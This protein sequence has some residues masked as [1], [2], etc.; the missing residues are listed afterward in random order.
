MRC[1]ACGFVSFPHLTTCKKCGKPLPTPVG[2]RPSS[3]P[4]KPPASRAA[5]RPPA[6]AAARPPATPPPV[7]APPD[8][9]ATSVS[10]D[11]N[12]TTPMRAARTA[13]PAPPGAGEEAFSFTLPAAASAD[14]R[15]H[16]FYDPAASLAVEQDFRPAG[17]WIR[18]VASFLDGI[19]GGIIMIVIAVPFVLS[20]GILGAM[21][22]PVAMAQRITGLGLAMNAIALLVSILYEVIFVGWRG[23]TPGKMLLGLKIIRVD[24][25]EVDYIKAFIRWIGKMV[26]G[27]I[28][29]IGYIMAAFTENKRAL[30]DYIASTRV[31]RL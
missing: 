19:V 7:A 30:H 11:P 17:F 25:G 10:G 23:Q 31:I 20:A 26:S 29:G 24:G 6:V 18:F 16:E 12:E 22:D 3:S 5:P 27:L 2:A 21:E 8:P 1:P 9:F 14:V 15:S 13:P 4:S 28:L